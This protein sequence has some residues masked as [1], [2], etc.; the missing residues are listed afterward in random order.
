MK[1]RRYLVISIWILSIIVTFLP[2]LAS[3]LEMK[4]FYCYSALLNLHCF[5][6]VPVI[7]IIFMYGLLIW[8]VQRQQRL[9]KESFPGMDTLKTDENNRRMTLIISRVVIL[10]LICYLPYL[11]EKHYFLGTVIQRAS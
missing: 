8:T 9:K 5:S 3:V 2:F 6:T 10:L 4:E 7:G 11:V 1:L